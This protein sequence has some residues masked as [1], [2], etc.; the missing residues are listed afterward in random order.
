METTYQNN[1][2]NHYEYDN[3]RIE[4]KLKSNEVEITFKNYRQFKLFFHK[5]KEEID[6]FDVENLILHL[7]EYFKI[8][9][10]LIYNVID[11]PTFEF[12]KIETKLSKELYDSEYKKLKTNS[13]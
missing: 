11:I 5:T 10:N 7:N 3:Y 6:M 13:K 2:I 9:N 1:S 4:T 12:R 8:N